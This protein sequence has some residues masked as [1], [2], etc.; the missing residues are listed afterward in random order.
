MHILFCFFSGIS[1]KKSGMKLCNLSN[2]VEENGE[3]PPKGEFTTYLTGGIMNDK[4]V[5]TRQ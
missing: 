2:D 5:R 3:S 4:S 1:R